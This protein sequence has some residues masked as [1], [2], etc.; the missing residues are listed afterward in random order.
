METLLMFIHLNAAVM[1]V[2]YVNR[3][4]IFGLYGIV[5]LCDYDYG[6]ICHVLVKLRHPVISLV[7]LLATMKTMDR[8]YPNEN[9]EVFQLFSVPIR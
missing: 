1:P 9:M 5:D 3:C 6:S 4:Y 8:E 2:V 7:A